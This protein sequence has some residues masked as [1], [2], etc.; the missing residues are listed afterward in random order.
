MSREA[1]KLYLLLV[2][3]TLVIGKE[4]R[5][6]WEVL[7]KA[8]GASLIQKK[9]N[10]LAKVLKR[11]GLADIR[12]IARSERARRPGRRADPEVRFTVFEFG[13]ARRRG[14]GRPRRQGEHRDA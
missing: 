4:G 7:K 11:Y 10:R 13:V 6:S 14:A 2:V 12:V 3:S 1:L 5:I 9:M 8:L